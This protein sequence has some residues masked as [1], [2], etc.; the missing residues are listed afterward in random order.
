MSINPA[1]VLV[2][3]PQID[4]LFEFG[5]ECS[6]SSGTGCVDPGGGGPLELGD[7]Q[8]F[9]PNDIATGSL[10]VADSGNRRVQVFDSTGNFLFK[11]G[12]QCFLSNGNG[13]DLSAPGAVEIGDGQFNSI[14]GIGVDGLGNI[15]VADGGPNARV[16]VFDPSGVFLFKFGS[17]CFLSNGNGCV[18]PDGGGP[19]ELGDEQFG[20]IDD[21]T[22]ADDGTVYVAEQ[23]NARIQVLD[24]S[25]NFLFKFGSFGTGD[26]NFKVP[27]V[28][29]DSAQNIYVSDGGSGTHVLQ[30]FDPLG[31]FLF[32]FGS[33]GNGEVEGQLNIPNRIGID[34]TDRIYVS[35]RSF[36][37]RILV[38]DSAGD[39]QFRFGMTGSNEGEFL[40]PLGVTIDD[41]DNIFVVDSLNRRIQAFGEATIAPIVANGVWVGG[42]AGTWS[43]SANWGN[44]ILPIGSDNIII[45]GNVIV[46]LDI[47]F[48]LSTGTLTIENGS[49]LIIGTGGSL[50]NNSSNTITVNGLLTI[51]GGQTL[52][53]FAT[54]T[55]EITSNGQIDVLGTIDNNGGTIGNNGTI[56]IT[57]TLFATGIS[58]ANGATI[59]NNGTI[60]LFA[61]GGGT[62]ILSTGSSTINNSGDI[63]VSGGVFGNQ[64][65]LNNSGTITISN[66]GPLINTDGIINNNSGGIIDNS[67][68]FSNSGTINNNVGGTI[69]SSGSMPNNAGSTFNN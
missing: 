52:F 42:A 31:N 61:G 6:I 55:I 34:S 60:T 37:N 44:G 25:G 67:S 26:G 40:Q 30:K 43:N 56:T 63:N 19:L 48:T 33:S 66:N 27:F 4:F 38:F 28:E 22:V 17:Q 39:F 47:S 13:C 12:S 7:G 49:E 65:I 5:S 20:S 41:S 18:D 10:V 3:V 16:Q 14:P 50:S 11:F 2:N 64:A 24:P 62:A 46:T 1:S 58:N 54:G 53:N 68:V 29:I 23:S 45:D 32:S 8:F 36:L 9:A 21:L 57:P 69:N 15:Y 35:D 59:G 51:N